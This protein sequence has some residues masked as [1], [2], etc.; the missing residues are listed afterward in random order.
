MLYFTADSRDGG[1]RGPCDPCC[2]K[3]LTLQA[4]ETNLMTIDYTSWATPLGWV[5]PDP[6]FS[7]ETDDSTCPTGEIDGF[8]PPFNTDYQFATVANGTVNID[9]SLNVSPAGNT[10]TYRILPFG[11]VQHGG[12]DQ[13]SNGVYQYTAAGGYAGYDYFDFETMDAQG[14]VT[15]NTVVISVGQHNQK[16]DNARLSKT[17]YV[18]RQSISVDRYTQRVSFPITMPVTVKPCQSFRLS[19]RQPAKDCDGNTFYHLS[20]YDITSG[21]C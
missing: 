9:L 2:C 11:G 7:V 6:E 3:S 13:V 1:A 18:D 16:R 17:P 4:G 21:K 10:F 14:R 12:L 5:V 15:T 8:P 20:C 19:I